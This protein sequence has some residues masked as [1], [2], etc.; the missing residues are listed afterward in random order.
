MPEIASANRLANARRPGQG[1][2][3]RSKNARRP[4]ELHQRAVPCGRWIGRTGERIAGLAI[5]LK[6]PTGRAPDVEAVPGARVFPMPPP[7]TSLSIRSRPSRLPDDNRLSARA[8]ASA[9]SSVQPPRRRVEGTATGYIDEPR[10]RAAF[11]ELQRGPESVDQPK[12]EQRSNRS[13]PDAFFGPEGNGRRWRPATLYLG[14]LPPVP[15]P[16][17]RPRI[18][19]LADGLASSPP[20]TFEVG[21]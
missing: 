21:F 6:G 8:S 1:G 12:A 10:I 15:D 13:A 14:V 2:C 4:G 19:H 5:A 7:P 16:S 17:P 3:G 20:S 18:S 11:T 9:V